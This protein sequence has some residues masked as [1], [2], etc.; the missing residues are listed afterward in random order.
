MMTEQE[1]RAFVEGAV[2][3]GDRA[4]VVERIVTDRIVARWMADQKDAGEASL[5]RFLD[6]YDK[7]REDETVE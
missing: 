5:R 6:A 1:I 2:V 3:T 4:T 7:L